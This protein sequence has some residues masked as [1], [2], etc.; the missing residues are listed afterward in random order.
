MFTGEIRLPGLGGNKRPE[1][2]EVDDRSPEVV[3]LFVKVPHT[4]LTEVSRMVL[5]HIGP[6]MML[7]TSH[8]AAR[9]ISWYSI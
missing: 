9:Y 8:L 6:V 7:A 2:V 1:L 4:D 3:L 5:V